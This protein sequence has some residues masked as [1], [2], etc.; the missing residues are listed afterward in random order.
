[1]QRR[2]WL[3]KRVFTGVVSCDVLP[4]TARSNLLCIRRNN[5][6]ISVRENG[7]ECS[8]HS[9]LSAVIVYLARAEEISSIGISISAGLYK[10][11]GSRPSKV[12]HSNRISYSR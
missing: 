1:M 5:L 7:D 8:V 11:L 12:N 9:P 10:I 3:G 2:R 6:D 4:A